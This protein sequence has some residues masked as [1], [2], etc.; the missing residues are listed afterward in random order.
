[1]AFETAPS[2]SPKA[3]ATAS[4]L[5]MNPSPETPL[6]RTQSNRVLLPKLK[7]DPKRP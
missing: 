4:R 7:P 6:W 2:P 1:M 5:P 3:Q